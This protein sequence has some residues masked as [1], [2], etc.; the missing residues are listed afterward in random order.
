MTTFKQ[1]VSFFLYFRLFKTI[2]SK[3]NCRWLDSNCWS[4]NRCTNYAT[5]TAQ[6]ENS[7]FNWHILA[8][9]KSTR[10]L[11]KERERMWK[12]KT[13]KL[14]TLNQYVTKQYLWPDVTFSSAGFRAFAA[15]RQ[16]RDIKVLDWKISDPP[17]T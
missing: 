12:K 8:T 17:T 13:C 6:K 1:F 11:A 5:T 9:K 3:L 10:K 4:S 15:K 2:D 16:R 7:S 14:T